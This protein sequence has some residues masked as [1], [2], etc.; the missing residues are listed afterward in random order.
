MNKRLRKKKKFVKKCNECSK[1][2]DTRK[3]EHWAV[4][5]DDYFIC[6]NCDVIMGTY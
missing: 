1:T 4:I 6:D 3:V 5:G 2:F